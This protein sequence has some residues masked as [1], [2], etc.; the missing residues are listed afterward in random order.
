MPEFSQTGVPWLVKHGLKELSHLSPVKNWVQVHV[1]AP[2]TTLQVPPLMH[3][4]AVQVTAVLVSQMAPSKPEAHVHL[5][6]LAVGEQVP[7]FWHGLLTHGFGFS[8]KKPVNSAVHVHE[9]TLLPLSTQVPP[10]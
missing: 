6:P 7:L 10:F 1:V 5:N 2:S 8:H 9:A 3:L 4:L